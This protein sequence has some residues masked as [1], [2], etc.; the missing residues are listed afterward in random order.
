[1]ARLVL[2]DNARAGRKL[3]DLESKLLSLV[4]GQDEAIHEI[5]TGYQSHVTG[6]SPAGRPIGSLLFLGPTGSGKAR[7]VEA[8]AHSLLNDPRAMIKI[9]CAEYQH[10]HEV[11]KLVGA[12]PGY[13]GHR[14]THPVLRAIERLLVQ[15]LSNVMASGQIQR[16]DYIYVSRGDNSTSFLLFHEAATRDNWRIAS[17]PAA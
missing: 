7:I 17:S 3:E 8:T 16:G 12:P 10:S 1:M 11:A 14:E 15:P 13:L 5:V 2:V 9:D 4:V 6:L